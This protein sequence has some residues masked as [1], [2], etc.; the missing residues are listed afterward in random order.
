LDWINF[1]PST[2]FVNEPLNETWTL[3]ALCFSLK[4][5]VPVELCRME[6]FLLAGRPPE[7]F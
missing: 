2:R 1:Q 7:T 6:H 5:A 4:E 3:W